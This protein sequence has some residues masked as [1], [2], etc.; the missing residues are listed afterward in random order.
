MIRILF[1][2][3]LEHSINY[4]E[5]AKSRLLYETSITADTEYTK[6]L[7]KVPS[8]QIRLGLKCYG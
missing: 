5:E 1:V 3:W 4:V 7:L 8:H 6:V 2:F